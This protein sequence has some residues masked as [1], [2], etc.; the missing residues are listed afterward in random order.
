M[1][2]S[3]TLYRSKTDKVIGGVSGGLSDYL[4]IDV[5]IIRIAFVLLAMFGGGGLLI[6]IILWIVMPEEQIFI[7]TTTLVEEEV[8]DPLQEVEKQNR[9]T[10]T[11]LIAGI[12]LIGIGAIL[13]LDNLIPFYHIRDFWPLLLVFAG[14]VIMKPDLFKPSKNLNHENQ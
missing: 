13:I 14:V 6:Y 11:S 5:V 8:V 7:G 2:N 12:I 9:R 3:K 4:D 1:K 10:N